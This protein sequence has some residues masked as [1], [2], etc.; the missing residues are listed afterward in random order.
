MAESK[1]KFIVLANEKYDFE[2]ISKSIYSNSTKD[3]V[4]Y[5]LIYCY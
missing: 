1:S 2:T 5:Q 4:P 3:H